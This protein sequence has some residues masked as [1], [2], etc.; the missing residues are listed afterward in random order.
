MATTNY[1]I[2]YNDQRFQTVEAEKKAALDNVNNTY[3]SMVNQ[4]DKY[5]QDQINAAKDYANT[6]QQIQQQNTDFAIE[7]INQ[8]KAQ[9]AKDYT[10]EQA[11]SYVDWQKQS[12]NY[13]ANAETMAAQGLSG[14]G[15]SESSQVSMYN[16]YQNRIASARET[17]NQAV[18]NY[19][20][21]IKE[22]QLANNSKL[23]EIAYQALQTQLEL[24][25]QGF[26]YKNTLLQTQLEQQNETEDR[27]YQRW[28]NVQSQIN[29]ENQFAES[30]RQYEATQ[31]EQKRQYEATLAEQKR[32]YDADLAYKQAQLAEQKRQ[33]DM[34]QKQWEA[35]Y[36]LAKKNSSSSSS[37]S[38][39]SSSSSKSSSSGSAAI[40][41]SSSS[42]TS[43]SKSSSATVKLS[44][45]KTGYL[46]PMVAYKAN[47]GSRPLN[48]RGLLEGGYV[49][50]VTYGGKTYYYAVKK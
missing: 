8:Q 29:T 34:E 38:S 4:S 14:T 16:Q 37:R 46:D 50:K 39:S 5:Y 48:S 42:S 12:N 47:G 19:D 2:D 23:A 9:A 35:E 31:A 10:K 3:N 27:Y 32:Q 41:K 30:I 21:S 28:Q 18:L 36:A 45:G 26:Q 40:N 15:Y 33:A 13:G 25:L 22:A 1:D 7:K 24:S 11:A 49:K 17:Y 20:N 6:Q 44:N 43:S